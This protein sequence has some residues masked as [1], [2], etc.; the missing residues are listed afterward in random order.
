MITKENF[1]YLTHN[2]D[3]TKWGL[4]L[5]VV[6]LAK[7]EPETNYPPTGHPTGYDF[8]WHKGRILQEYQINYIT[9]GEG[10]M[11]TREGSYSIKA[12]SVILLRPNVWHRYRPLKQT[13]WMEHYVGF[14]GEIADK[15]IKSSDILNDS[16]VLQ[17]GFQEDII[18]FFQDIFNQAK[19]EQPGYH[20]VCSGLVVHILG[21][22]VS[23]K[24]NE[25]FRHSVIEKTIHKACLIIRDNPAKN[26]NIEEL[27]KDLNINYSLFRKAFKRY[28]GL[29]PIQYH[30]SLRLKQAVYLLIN[31]DL[32]VKE[33]SFNLGFCSE[34]YF[35]KLFKEK[36]GRTT[37]EFR[38]A[39]RND[40][41]PPSPPRSSHSVSSFC[42]SPGTAA[43]FRVYPQTSSTAVF[44]VQGD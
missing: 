38:K 15:I 35:C 36:T 14:M 10:I 20:Q 19:T 17:V 1:K 2:P 11:E 32:S 44:P 16:P 8:N 29:S 5:T 42:Q 6:G 37:S 4:Y 40:T 9:E 33:I 41:P 18:H 31:T 22:L 23:L 3:D 30:T 12:G 25:N 43:P 39:N 13:G 34:F 7:V 28:T 21:Q 24:K 26:L 27:A